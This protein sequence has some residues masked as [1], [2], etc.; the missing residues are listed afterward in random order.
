MDRPSKT[1]SRAGFYLVLLFSFFASVY[2]AIAHIAAVLAFALWI[3]E[4]TIFRNTDWV[5]EEMFF[6]VAG[7]FL[8][9]L[10]GFIVSRINAS[11]A[12][13]PYTGYLAIFYFVVHRF[14]SLS[15]KRKMIV[16]TFIAGVVLSSGLDIAMRLSSAGLER[17][18]MNPAPERISFYI[19]VVFAMILAFY[20]EGKNFG[21]KFFFALIALPLAVI[22]FLSFNVYVILILLLLVFIIGVCKDRT[23]LFP[24]VILLIL[25]YSGI[26]EIPQN[27]SSTGV[28]GI[29]KSSIRNSI[30]YGETIKNISFFGFDA[31]VA[32][33]G[34]A[35][36][37]KPLFMELLMSSGPL[38]LLISSWILVKQFRSDFVKFRKITFRE[39]KA[40]HLG[41][42]LSIVAFIMMSLAGSIFSSG[43][44][45]LVFWMILGMS[46]I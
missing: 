46:E 19:L 15:E 43:S 18:L 38:A 3:V 30:E 13:L 25:F 2:P 42:I 5:R 10:L 44:A 7:F 37:S 29:L 4:Q 27:I 21:E 34:F 11:V 17:S 16:W 28:I 32:S 9:T 33:T 8:F 14:V 41:I 39:M 12:A 45:V 24:L 31:A 22:A 20:S 26:I 36:H 35:G 1:F 23:A 40:F 6:P